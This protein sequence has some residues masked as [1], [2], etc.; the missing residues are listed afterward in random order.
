MISELERIQDSDK[1]KIIVATNRLLKKQFIHKDTGYNNDFIAIQNHPGYVRNLME[2]LGYHFIHQPTFFGIVPDYDILPLRKKGSAYTKVLLGLRLIYQMGLEAQ[3]ID[4]NYMV[5]SDLQEVWS[6]LNTH[7]VK[8]FVGND[9]LL[10]EQIVNIQKNNI[11]LD[12]KKMTDEYENT[13]SYTFKITK[14]I[15]QVINY[16]DIEDFNNTQIIEVVEEK[17]D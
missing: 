11:I 6:L 9:S 3:K 2:S 5:E 1:K 4:E 16:A 7:G 10:R 13:V 15:E 12:Y 14:A 17:E 8:D